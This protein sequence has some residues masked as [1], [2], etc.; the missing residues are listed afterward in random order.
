MI[1]D[2]ILPI[3]IVYYQCVDS[4]WLLKSTVNGYLQKFV[5]I[6]IRRPV[7]FILPTG[8]PIHIIT[9][10]KSISISLLRVL[11]FLHLHPTEACYQLSLVFKATPI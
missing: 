7:G 8:A 2:G 11:L 9:N 6:I 4:P 1:N 5:H 3:K 10:V